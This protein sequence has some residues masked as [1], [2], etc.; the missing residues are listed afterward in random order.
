M[1]DYTGNNWSHGNTKKRLQKNLE[2][3]PAKHTI[4]SLK[5]TTILEHHTQCRK[6]CSLKT[7][8]WAVGINIGSK[9]DVPGRT[10]LWQD[11]NNNNNNNNNNSNNNNNNNNRQLLFI[12]DTSNIPG[13]QF[14]PTVDL[15]KIL[16]SL[17]PGKGSS[18]SQCPCLFSGIWSNVFHSESATG[19]LASPPSSSKTEWNIF[20][21]DH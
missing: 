3:T 16:H 13:G 1:Y 9:G 11:N 21:W 2:T 17:W 18:I 20:Y 10:G 19:W 7:Q 8:V 6:Y 12:S 15:S 4:N 14:H 5:R